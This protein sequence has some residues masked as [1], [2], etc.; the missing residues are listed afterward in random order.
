M[1]IENNIGEYDANEG[2]GPMKENGRV[3]FSTS[4]KMNINRIESWKPNT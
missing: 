2:K 3:G 4:F 1:I